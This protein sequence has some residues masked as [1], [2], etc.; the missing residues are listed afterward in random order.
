MSTLLELKTEEEWNQYA[1]SVPSNTLQVLYFKAEWAAPCKQMTTVLQTL[2][3]SYPVTEPLSTSWVSLDAED[4]PDVSDSF[5]VTAVPFLVLQRNGQVLET[6]S[7]SD[8]MKVRAAI[9][10]HSNSTTVPT[11]A[12][13]AAHTPSNNGTSAK[14]VSSSA[15]TTQ[16]SATAPEIP[17]AEIKEDK[18]AL[19]NRL[20]SLVKAAPVMLFM[21]G[22]PSAP[23][24]GFSRQL[25]ALLREN[26]VKYGFF[27]ILADDEVRQGL[28]EFA[29]W[30][31]FPQ[32]WVDGELVGGLDI[33][34]EEMGNDPDF[35]KPYSVVKSTPAAPSQETA[36]ATA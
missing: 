27:N 34:K 14:N 32:L 12:N 30:P 22:T 26:S 35:L 2:A 13:G 5:D 9:E 8:A 18:E 16:D 15:P 1:A 21:K 20:S 10:K 3:S 11:T 4:V 29:D 25:V 6:V 33:V 28:K 36:T 19:H 7:G 17:S 31:T 24:C 23:Q